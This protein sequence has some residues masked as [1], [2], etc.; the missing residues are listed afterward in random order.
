MG[1]VHWLAA[2]CIACSVAITATAGGSGGG[3]DRS[4]AG[5][6]APK[7][8]LAAL[9]AAQAD[10]RQLIAQRGTAK[11]TAERRARRTRFRDLTDA[12]ATAT[13]AREHRGGLHVAAPV[14]EGGRVEHFLGAHSALVESDGRPGVVA[15]SVPLMA[16]AAH[17]ELEPVDLGLVPRDGALEPKLGVSDVRIGRRLGDG[18]AVA[19]TGVRVVAAAGAAGD[20]AELRQGRAVWPNALRDTD[21]VAIAL[22]AGAGVAYQLRS[23]D[24]P[25]AIRMP[26][27]V[28][29]G[30]TLQAAADGGL[31]VREDGRTV[32]R[33]SAP[34]AVGADGATVPA[35]LV[36]D[37]PGQVSLA[38]AHREADAAY[39]V[40]VDPEITNAPVNGTQTWS[41]TSYPAGKVSGNWSTASGWMQ[42]WLNYA[43]DAAT[44]DISSSWRMTAPGNSYVYAAQVTGWVIRRGTCSGF[45][46]WNGVAT[47]GSTGSRCGEV[48]A[49]NVSMTAP[50]SGTGPMMVGWY[51]DFSGSAGPGF[52]TTVTGI[53]FQYSDNDAPA[54]PTTNAPSGWVATAPSSIAVTGQDAGVGMKAL[55]IS[56]FGT[57]WA[58]SASHA[59]TGA[60]GSFCPASMT[61]TFALPATVPEGEN[62]LQATATDLIGRATSASVPLRIDR[63]APAV[64][65][66]GP[67]NDKAGGFVDTATTLRV[68]ATDGNAASPDPLAQR[69]G[70]RSAELIVDGSAVDAT[71]AGVQRVDQAC[72]TSCPLDRTLDFDPTGLPEGPHQIS[73]RAVDNVGNV[74]TSAPFTVTLDKTAPSLTVTGGLAAAE[75]T[76]LQPGDYD[77]T[78]DTTD[79]TGGVESIQVLVDGVQRGIVEQPCPN[80]G[81]GLSHTYTHTGDAFTP[82]PHEVE[83]KVKDKSGKEKSKKIPVTGNP[84]LSD[85]AV[86][87]GFEEYFPLRSLAAGAG[88]SASVNLASGNFT[89]H[90]RPVSDVGRGLWTNVDVTYNSR[91]SELDLGH[92]YDE[93]G[94]GFSLAISSLTRVNEAL[95]VRWVDKNNDKKND[96]ATL[97]DADGTMH[98]FTRRM[99]GTTPTQIFDAPPGVNVHLRRFNASPQTVEQRRKVWAAT[100]P[101]GVTHFFDEC[102]YERSAE[103]R[104]GNA[105]TFT[106]EDEECHPQTQ[107]RRAKLL[108]VT[109]A[110]GRSLRLFYESGSPGT[111]SRVDYILDHE[112]RKL[113][114]TY[115]SNKKL[116][117]ITEATGTA[118]TRSFSFAYEQTGQ[119]AADKDVIEITDP[120]GNRTQIGYS[121]DH[122]GE[123]SL[124]P[125]FGLGERVIRLTDRRAKPITFDYVPGSPFLETRLTDRRSKLWRY[126][127]DTAF[128]VR[129]LVDPLGV[130]TRFGWDADNN[131]AQVDEAVGTPREAH[132]LMVWNANGQLLSHTDGEL[133]RTQ[134]T[135]RHSNGVHEAPSG[136]DAGG[137]FVSDVETI[138][139]PRGTA[140]AAADDFTTRLRYELTGDPAGT[141]DRGNVRSITDPEGFVSTLDYT[142]QGVLSR[143][144]AETDRGQF[145]VTTFENFDA[146]GLP[147]LV[148]DPR[149]NRT[150]EA[151]DGQWHVRYTV[152]G[153][154]TRVT[155]PRGTAP[156]APPSPTQPYTTQYG[157]DALRRQVS[158]RIP[159]LTGGATPAFIDRS[160]AYDAN[161]N[162]VRTVDGE[163]QPT[164][165][166]YSAMDD[167][168]SETSPPVAHELDSAVTESETTRITYDAE[169]NV[170]K[171]ESPRGTRTATVDD[172]T[173]S[174]QYDGAGRPTV[175]RQMSRG[176]VV[177]DLI[178]SYAYDE[179]GNLTGVADPAIN[180]A[181]GDPA[182]N[183]TQD[184]TR[185]ISYVY[186]L[187]DRRTRSIEHLRDVANTKLT[188]ILGY[189]ADANLI[190]VTDPRGPGHTT[191]YEYDGRDLLSAEVDAMG[192]RT[193]YQLRGDQR[194]IR[195]T[196]PNGTATAAAGDFET[197]MSYDPMG[198]LLERTI[199]R[200][201]GQPT[202]GL[203]WKAVYTR[204]EIGDPI[205]IT[206]GRGRAFTNTFFDTGDLR[207]TGRP[208]W[209]QFDGTGIGERDPEAGPAGDELGADA[210]TTQPG[211]SAAGDFGQMGRRPLP[212][213]IPRAGQTT[214]DYDREM[215]LTSSTDAAGNRFD[216]IRDPL[217][218]IAQTSQPFDPGNPITQRYR[219]DHNGNLRLIEDGEGHR[220]ELFHDQFERLERRRAPGAAIGTFEET[221]HRYDPNGNV[222]EIQTP[223]GPQFTWRMTYDALDRLTSRANPRGDTTTWEDFDGAG[224]PR[225]QISPRG[226][227]A[228]LSA[229][230]RATFTTR[231]TFDALNRVTTITDGLGQVTR[232]GYDRDSNLTEIDAPGAAAQLGGAIRRQVMRMT[233]DGR[234]LPYSTTTFRNGQERT[235]IRE[236]DPNGN[237]RRA[238]TPRGVTSDAAGRPV[239]RWADSDDPRAGTSNASKHATVN[240]YDAD[241]LLTATHLPWG[242]PVAADAFSGQNG[243]RFVQRFERDVRGRIMQITP[244]YD[245]DDADEA[246][247]I[248]RRR[249]TYTHFQNGWIKTA[250]DPDHEGDGN[251]TVM[252][253]QYGYDRRGFQS[254]WRFER[255]QNGGTPELKREI[256][257]VIAPNGTL[258]RREARRPGRATRGHSYTYNANHTMTSIADEDPEAEDHPGTRTT[259]IAVNAAERPV[260]VDETW[261]RGR[262]TTFLYDRN[263]NVVRR[264]TDGRADPPTAPVDPEQPYGYTGSDART[265]AFTYDALDREK[266]AA[267]CD[268]ASSCSA[269]AG[270]AR[271][272]STDWY[273]SGEVERRTKPS[274][275]VETRAYFEDGRIS[276][277]R[278]V[279]NGV[280]QKDQTYDYDENGNRTRDERG[281]YLHS[282]RDGLIKWTRSNGS[283]VSYRLLGSRAIKESIDTQG[284]EYEYRYSGDRLD[285]I[286]ASEAGQTAT[287]TL[288]YDALGATRFM[289]QQQ[290]TTEYQYDEFERLRRVKGF[291]APAGQSGD[292]YCYDALD[293]RALRIESSNTTATCA[294]ATPTTPGT[295][296]YAYV[297][298]TNMLAR[299]QT[300]T[301][302]IRTYDYDSSY[303]RLGRS[304][305]G[306]RY[307]SYAHDANGSVEGIEHADGTLPSTEQYPYDPYGRLESASRQIDDPPNEA[308]NEL[309]TADMKDN[310]FR[311]QGFYYDAG[312]QTYDM[313]A[314]D[315]RPD[316]ARFLSVDR[317]S[318]AYADLSLLA[319]PVTQNRYAFAGGNPITLVEVD[320]HEPP[321]SFTNPCDPIY[322]SDERCSEASEE[323]QERS[324]SNQQRFT[325]AYS[326]NW[327]VGRAT[328]PSRTSGSSGNTSSTT[329]TSPRKPRVGPRP[330]RSSS[331]PAKCLRWCSTAARRS[332]RGRTST[333]MT[334]GRCRGIWSS[335][336]AAVSARSAASRPAVG[337]S[338]GCAAS[339][340]EAR[341]RSHPCPDPRRRA[342]QRKEHE[343]STKGS[344]S[345]KA[346]ARSAS[347]SAFWDRPAKAG[348]GTTSSSRLPATSAASGPRLSTTPATSCDWT[349]RY[350]AR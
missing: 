296:E 30:A 334:R 310:P 184:A 254:L 324:A 246:A 9:A 323:D 151:G 93:I 286:V 35:R 183:A 15:S 325:Y 130:L 349:H 195:I 117:R 146:G 222:R 338:A 342:S 300:D 145:A 344:P 284:P 168:E 120:R 96:V 321:S 333:T 297:G 273:P 143:E 304:K 179:R 154:T 337:S 277:M 159:K 257:R 127:T 228:G 149:G 86:A 61:Q 141:A 253:L 266:T 237:L 1:R 178:S 70:V 24:S 132:Q 103:D 10:R 64:T 336:S 252:R 71:M 5:K 66:S 164:T 288:E 322:G 87:V 226:N 137:T 124:A 134:L 31:D 112:N 225:A 114:F 260:L 347:S 261:S 345:A 3:G 186:D 311:F 83:V 348:N 128:R 330:R 129:E 303:N 331:A 147:Q 214:F 36:V 152:A 219:R 221:L 131:L 189:D 275:A 28:P 346:S 270:G 20:P 229:A 208:S 259:Q 207:T 267:V 343:G 248:G 88:S 155:D 238:I 122:G 206:D 202:G 78:I 138:T 19:G 306:D 75:G 198:D 240:E 73:V 233:Y 113:D 307:Q 100:L 62:V 106:Y 235:V 17:G 289:R 298:L 326:E 197:R 72:G 65:L 97:T 40:L 126:R 204:D 29:P 45:Y 231:R 249:T 332:L 216:V 350:I 258:T 51:A 250:T 23:P 301:G 191:T 236:F 27:E 119:T 22:P 340:H 200:A 245:P 118:D 16:R 223:R 315:Y 21:V 175:E 102:G 60:Q 11:A 234:D 110:G 18:I 328:S 4:P 39:P 199:P 309:A 308:E 194:V 313:Q 162:V 262:D 185:R 84:K 123:A 54:T 160:T 47:V 58:P 295:R 136:I 82:G 8:V 50:Q 74:R 57:T 150:A 239:P 247:Q 181:G 161:D 316:I 192:G 140:T 224:N 44:M 211:K 63:S 92:G 276:Q 196:K 205:T 14:A 176:S 98:R 89:W 104:N 107:G 91:S 242:D 269:G 34:V 94:E 312:T 294:T 163:G 279:A 230:E 125:K 174:Y 2:A 46:I 48:T 182:T 227:V 69:S 283:T 7:P 37:A 157:Y 85:T 291:G 256:S 187:A 99:N 220:T 95:D 158:E 320:G 167:V 329:S 193:E 177:E 272:T 203:P 32:A 153:L 263:G 13:L 80:G 49:G 314:R 53:R 79:S 339:R 68:Q 188:T 243:K 105:L 281:T 302:A 166:T 293:R 241:N 67:L 282:A 201:D 264:Q 144:S 43:G 213:V 133:N 42:H 26:L 25:Q 109:D 56:G 6:P 77:L 290:G 121:D 317:Y 265:T 212:G 278:R 101:D 135:Y 165:R 217:G 52:S 305:V 172:F 59:C 341:S 111:S 33:I 268:N 38:V 81:C 327:K 255:V 171:V 190:A 271:V 90:H 169:Q 318:D 116:Q 12:A 210:E 173:T 215:R 251:A 209:W 280:Q 108:S 299:E 148:T 218:Q 232:A 244:A 76:T 41:F 170:E 55:K 142:A 287:A 285:E 139:T 319:D 156:A 274:S 115:Q 292:R 180:R 335:H